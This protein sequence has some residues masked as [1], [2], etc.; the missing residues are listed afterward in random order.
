[1][2]L[3]DKSQ[4]TIV[5]LSDASLLLYICRSGGRMSGHRVI[6]V[7]NIHF[8]RREIFPMASLNRIRRSSNALNHSQSK[9]ATVTQS[10]RPLF[11]AAKLFKNNSYKKFHLS[12]PASVVKR[13]PACFKPGWAWPM[14]KVLEERTRQHCG[15]QHEN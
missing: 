8:C 6:F 15:E 9:V 7:R 5:C 3:S 13:K 4:L 2:K 14:C 10:L 11:T 12:A 1:M